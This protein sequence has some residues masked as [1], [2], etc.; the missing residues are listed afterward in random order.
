MW[1]GAPIV[2]IHLG[3]MSACA[4]MDF[5]MFETCNAFQV[6]WFRAYPT[7]IMRRTCKGGQNAALFHITLCLA[8]KFDIVLIELHYIGTRNQEFLMI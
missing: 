8:V 1:V 3:S 7:N 6:K 5:K 2:I 4:R